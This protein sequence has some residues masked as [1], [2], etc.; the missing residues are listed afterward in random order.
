MVMN[1]LMMQALHHKSMTCAVSDGVQT[2]AAGASLPASLEVCCQ[3]TGTTQIQVPDFSA[4]V[5][6]QSC[7][8]VQRQAD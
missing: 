2:Q 1:S 5:H 4:V 6:V 8:L 7:E 3:Q